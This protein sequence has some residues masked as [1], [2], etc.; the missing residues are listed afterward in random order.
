[1][2][3]KL[4]IAGCMEHPRLRT[5]L[6]KQFAVQEADVDLADPD[7][8]PVD[9]RNWQAIVNCEYSRLY[10]DL[11]W[12]LDIW[13]VD[14]LPQLPTEAE[15]ATCLAEQ[16][17]TVVLYPAPEPLP[18]A[19]WLAAPGGVLTRARLYPVDEV[20]NAYRIDAVEQAVPLLPQVT[21][22]RIPEVIRENRPPAPL[23]EDFESRL[24]ALD[25]EVLE[26]GSPSWYACT[27]LYN[28][29][30][31]AVRMTTGWP[32]SGWYPAEYYAENLELRDLLSTLSTQL[33][34]DVREGFTTTLS[35]IDEQYREATED[36]RGKALSQALG[37]S[38]VTLSLRAWWWLRRPHVLP[39]DNQE[40]AG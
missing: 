10:G 25:E 20:E 11:N 12:S 19:Y 35:R 21:P 28:W 18:S 5:L 3:Y 39:W 7:E 40:T 23:A 17:G 33:H 8:V 26:T 4:L 6:A 32:P 30:R 24:R 2:N 36:D 29:E 38:Q 14:G 37:E 22:A 15:L 1:M 34:E 9:A 31:L 27:R 13:V 16:L